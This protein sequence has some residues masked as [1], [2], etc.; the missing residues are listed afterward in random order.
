M[1]D[2]DNT[3]TT[4]RTRKVSKTITNNDENK[5]SGDVKK[6]LEFSLGEVIII[7]LLTA[8][9][10]SVA[11]GII[12]FKNYDKLSIKISSNRE[13]NEIIENYNYIIDNYVEEVDKDEL[14]DAAI[15][16]MYNY[17]EDEYSVYMDKDVTNSLQE[18]LNGKYSGIGVEITMN[19]ENQILINRIFSDSPAEKAGLKKGDILIGLDGVDL[20]DKTSSYVAETI[21]GSNKDSFVIKYLRNNK[22]Y[23]VTINKKIV[24]IDSVETEEYDNVGYIKI[25]TFSAT[26]SNQV[27]E[28]I[29]N[30]S[31]KVKSIVIDLRNNT[32]GYLNAAYEI[33]DL[34]IE[35][36]KIIY[37]LKDR[38]NKVFSYPAKNNALRKFDKIVIIIN[39]YSASASEVVTLALKENLNATVVGTKSYGKGTVQETK[40]LSS[41]AMVKYTSSYWLSPNGNTINK[42]GIIPDIEVLK[43]SEQLKK[44]LEVAK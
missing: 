44:A 27:K 11:S 20:K 39:E 33:S 6:S 4:K 14:I 28:K 7:V 43:E 35:K 1:E 17:L 23:T 25:E 34:F 31:D 21:K 10:V 13:T 40:I 41:G 30:F 22:E 3:K 24:S 12:I 5:K 8:V 2:S 9:L 18:Q 16:G 15:S 36:G 38:E 26:T 37:Q 19:E 29:E 42:I 32:G